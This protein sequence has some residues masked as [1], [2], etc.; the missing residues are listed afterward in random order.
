MI[1]YQ[2]GAYVE[3][4]L[5]WPAVHLNRM[6]GHNNLKVDDFRAAKYV[7]VVKSVMCSEPWETLY[8]IFTVRPLPGF[9]CNVN[10]SE[11]LR[12]VKES[13]LTDE[14]LKWRD[15]ITL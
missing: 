5:K 3:F 15:F 6:F 4:M 13:E 7:G 14:E 2:K 11:I 8:V 1:K 12:V 10:E 9:R